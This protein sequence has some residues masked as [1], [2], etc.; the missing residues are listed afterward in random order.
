MV[1]TSFFSI[2]CMKWRQAVI[3]QSIWE[4]DSIIIHFPAYQ[5]GLLTPLLTCFTL[6]SF[7]LLLEKN[8]LSPTPFLRFA[9]LDK[10]F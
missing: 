1:G 4:T 8:I 10:I 6:L 2:A 3:L 7:S 5:T 9:F